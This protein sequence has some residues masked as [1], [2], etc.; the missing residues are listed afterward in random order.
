MSSFC[1]AALNPSAKAARLAIVAAGGVA[2]A[3][4]A[5]RAAGAA[6]AH[7]AGA[8]ELIAALSVNNMEGIRQA[9]AAQGIARDLVCALRAH[10]DDARVALFAADAIGDCCAGSVTV[11]R[12]LHALGALGAL[13]SALARHSRNAN[14]A[15]A[16]VRAVGN[17][18]VG[19][20]EVKYDLCYG[21]AAAT[22]AA[23]HAAGAACAGLVNAFGRA[24]SQC[25]DITI[26]NI[27]KDVPGPPVM[28]AGITTITFM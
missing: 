11:K 13:G 3:A 26:G 4:R 23:V 6:S 12:E 27:H 21:A 28:R 19:V 22:T 16:A 20:P 15:H 25:V 7:T 5:L 18:A 1:S 2:L 17:L 24:V 9:L 8:L 14:V 10:A